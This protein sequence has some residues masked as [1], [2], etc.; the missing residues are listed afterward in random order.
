MVE[1]TIPVIDVGPLRDGRTGRARVVE[2]IGAG[3]RDWGF[4]QVTGHGIES[5]LV[6]R[7]WQETWG[8]F[9][10]STAQKAAFART[11]DNAR[12]YYNRELTKT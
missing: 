6:D 2:A 3:C 5:Q 7:V 11:G 8:L 4:F 1:P 10:L 12:G 9:S